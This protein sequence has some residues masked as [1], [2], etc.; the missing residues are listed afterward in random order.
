MMQSIQ[1]VFEKSIGSL[2]GLDLR[3]TVKQAG[4]C[5]IGLWRHPLIITEIQT[6]ILFHMVLIAHIKE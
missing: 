3:V 4:A 1:I 5:A 6:H 2:T